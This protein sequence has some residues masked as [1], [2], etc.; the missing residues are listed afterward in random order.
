MNCAAIWQPCTQVSVH[1]CLKLYMGVAVGT[2]SLFHSYKG[3]LSGY[4]REKVRGMN[5]AIYRSLITTC[6]FTRLNTVF[7]PHDVIIKVI[8][9]IN[10]K[11][12][13]NFFSS[14]IQRWCICVQRNPFKSKRNLVDPLLFQGLNLSITELPTPN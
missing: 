7:L 8:I 12:I 14:I 1:V 2:R 3:N 13:D 4:G 5:K 6:K 9:N 11:N 10:V